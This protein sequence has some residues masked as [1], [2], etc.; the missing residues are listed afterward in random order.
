MCWKGLP[1]KK[2]LIHPATQKLVELIRA[3]APPGEK[4]KSNGMPQNFYSPCG[5]SGVDSSRGS[6]LDNLDGCAADTGYIWAA[7]I[8][9][10]D[11]VDH[12]D[13]DVLSEG[14]SARVEVLIH[15]NM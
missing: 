14:I 6:F 5:K 1:H 10:L 13:Q 12:V 3:L 8:M 11:R 15:D 2:V 7:S 4:K 9:C